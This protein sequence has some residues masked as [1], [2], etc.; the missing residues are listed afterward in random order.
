MGAQAWTY[1]YTTDPPM[2]WESASSYCR[3]HYTDMVAIQNQ[4]EISYLNDML[5]HSSAYYWIG[6]RKIEEQWTWVGTKKALTPE[7]ENW[8]TGEPNNLGAGQDCVEIYIKRQTDTAMW[9]DENCSKR[10]GAICYTG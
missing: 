7:A 1:N 9:N 4:A 8:A 5:P 2:D 6:I 10:K 3:Q